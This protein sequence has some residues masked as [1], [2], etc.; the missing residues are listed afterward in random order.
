M[1]QHDFDAL[2]TL[3]AQGISVLPV[4]RPLAR[5]SQHAARRQNSCE[6]NGRPGKAGLAINKP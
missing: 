6:V 3:A 4:D 2:L 1:Y 5:R